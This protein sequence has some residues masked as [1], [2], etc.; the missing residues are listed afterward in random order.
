MSVVSEEQ[1]RTE[2]NHICHFDSSKVTHRSE[3]SR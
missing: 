1:Q 3:W 2:R